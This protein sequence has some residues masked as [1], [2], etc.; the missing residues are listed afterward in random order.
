MLRENYKKMNEYINPSEELRQETIGRM[1]LE[2]NSKN[3]YMRSVISVLGCLLIVMLAVPVLAAEVPAFQTML[4][5]LSPQLAE[6]LQPIQKVSDSE[7][8]RLTVQGAAFYKDTAVVYFDIQDLEGDRLSEKSSLGDLKVGEYSANIASHYT[9]PY[10]C[11][12]VGYDTKTK[13]AFYRLVFDA[14]DRNV[15][16]NKKVFL[17]GHE[18]RSGSE[19]VTLGE[20]N[21][22][23]EMDFDESDAIS[24]EVQF[25]GENITVEI[26]N[27]GI[28]FGFSNENDAYDPY[29][30]PE[31]VV[32]TE[33]GT[34]VYECKYAQIY[35]ESGYYKYMGKSLTDIQSIKQI[36]IAD[37]VVFP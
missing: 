22:I 25:Y 14:V 24:K 11:E 21:I 29:V 17:R 35:P 9:L 37:V 23:F 30:F 16:K 31:V 15:L 8:I 32:E 2:S 6:Y 18:L 27:V 12:Q 28:E 13:K 20:W 5:N 4:Y 33:D 26:S 19:T 10:Y 1:N 7:G 36:K 34:K 3:P